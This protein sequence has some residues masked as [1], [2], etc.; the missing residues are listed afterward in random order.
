MDKYTVVEILP[1]KEFIGK[2]LAELGLRSPCDT[3]ILWIK[4]SAILLVLGK[5]DDIEKIKA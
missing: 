3:D 2:T 1:P 5:R 4:D